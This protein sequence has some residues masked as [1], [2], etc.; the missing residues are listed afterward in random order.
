MITIVDNYMVNTE[1][2]GTQEK[3][4]TLDI[5]ILGT[6]QRKYYLNS[7]FKP[8]MMAH[9]YKPR[10]WETGTKGSGIQSHPYLHS[11]FQANLDHTCLKK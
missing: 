8:H 3:T 5:D 1:L 10:T 9:T 6:F 7:Q 2:T 11:K 4:F